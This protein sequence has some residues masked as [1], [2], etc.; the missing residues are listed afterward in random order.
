MNQQIEI[1]QR[2]F[3]MWK[4]KK[5]INLAQIFTPAVH[6]VECYGAEYV[7]IQEIQRWITHKFKVQTVTCWDIKNIYHDGATYI[8]EWVFACVDH[9]KNFKFDGV[10]L[11][12]FKDLQ[13]AE[14]KEFESK[15]S[16][17]RPYQ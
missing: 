14:I 2:Y 12:T 6:Y 16:H 5:L 4:N 13:I 3:N 9:G 8:V 1:I 11:V 10:S 17:Y 15:H 7:G